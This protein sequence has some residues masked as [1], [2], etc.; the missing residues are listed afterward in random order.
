M[1]EPSISTQPADRHAGQVQRGL[2]SL[3]PNG[4]GLILLVCVINALRRTLP[5]DE[6]GA[7][8]SDLPGIAAWLVVMAQTTATGLLVALPVAVAGWP[9]TTG[10]RMRRG[11]VIPCWRW[12]SRSRRSPA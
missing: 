8:F 4:L 1:N 3:T 5:K 9:H 2:R 11:S 10:R 12:W 6:L 7:F